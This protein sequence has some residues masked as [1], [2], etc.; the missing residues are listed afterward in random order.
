MIRIV[1]I[2]FLAVATNFAQVQ[3]SGNLQSYIDSIIS[4]M[5]DSVGGNEYQHPDVNEQNDWAEV[6]DSILAESYSA[7]HTLALSLEYRVIEYTDNSVSPNVTYYLLQ[8]EQSGSNY[9]GTYI[10]NPNPQRAQLVIQSPHPKKDYNTGKQGF[11][12]FREVGARAFFLSGTSRCS[13][14]SYSICDGTTSVCTG[15]S[16]DYRMSD[17]AHTDD[18]TFQ[19]TTERM[20]NNNSDLIFIQLHG[21]SKLSSD[22]YVIMSNGVQDDAPPIDYL[23]NLKDNLYAEDTTLTFKIAH[24]DTTWDRLLGTTNT[25]GRF[26]N[27]SGDPCDDKATV[28]TGQFLHIEQERYK[29]RNDQ[30]GWEKMS[31]AI[32]AT[33]PEVLLPVELTTF[34]GEL[35]EDKTVLIKWETATEVNNYG[36]DVERRSSSLTE[37]DKLGFVLGH[38]TTNSPKNYEF[39]DFE[40]PNSDEVSYR[41]K[42]IDNDGTFSYSKVV[43]VDLTNITSVDDEL[44][45]EFALEQNYPN[46]FNPSTKISFTIADVGDEYIRPLH[47]RLIVYDILGREVATL[48]NEKLNSGNYE[49]TFD[50]SHLTSGMYL[51]KL[52]YGDFEATK[53][54]LLVK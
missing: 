33:F 39:T 13:S 30:A 49:V 9:W 23:S 52:I 29:L 4:N 3:L 53:K 20:L 35:L 48:L 5:P 8:M 37:W 25:Q 12:I 38:G 17:Q 44:V 31:N 7:A 50:A 28:N 1:S 2:F 10:F 43:T 45:Y 18:G 36:F 22:P 26:I 32:T 24:I 27:G 46:P 47:T 21:F 40:L 51:Y 19:I 42:Q 54:L 34:T 11:Y 16:E 15:S 6:I 41:L 14:S